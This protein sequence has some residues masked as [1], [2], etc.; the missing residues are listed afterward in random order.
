M[1]KLLTKTLSLAGGLS[2]VL[3]FSGQDAKAQSWGYYGWG[4][5]SSLLYPLTYLPYRLLYNGAYGYGN[6]GYALNNLMYQNAY[7]PY[8]YVPY[9]GKF[10]LGNSQNQPYSNN[11]GQFGYGQPGNNPQQQAPAYNTGNS[12]QQQPPAYNT[13]NGNDPNDFQWQEPSQ[14]N[15]PVSR[16]G[17]SAQRNAP[18]QTGSISAPN[19]APNIDNAA[20]PTAFE[21]LPPVAP[22]RIKKNSP[23]VD[24]FIQV[25]LTKFNGDISQALKDK[26]MYSWAQALNIVDRKKNHHINLSDS[27]KATVET[28]LKDDS[29]DARA[30]LETLKILLK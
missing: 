29:L 19:A 1:R 7:A 20:G 3:A 11:S 16:P 9:G 6:S 27:R 26:E 14:N 23:F 12:P 15:Q 10:G 13:G 2:L 17:K 4:L 24:G 25:V 18:A 30:K 21:N 22:E 8:G 5:G 28:V